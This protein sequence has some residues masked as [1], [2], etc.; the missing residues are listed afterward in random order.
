MRARISS[1]TDGGRYRCEVADP[2]SDGAS[3][4]DGVRVKDPGSKDDVGEGLYDV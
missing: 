4:G 1:Y 3:G 2:W